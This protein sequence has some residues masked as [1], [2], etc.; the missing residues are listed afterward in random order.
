VQRGTRHLH[1]TQG[2]RFE[3]GHRCDLARAT[4]LEPNVTDASLYPLS[5]ELVGHRPSG[6]GGT[7]AQLGLHLKLVHLHYHPVG[8]VLTRRASPLSMLHEANDLIHAPQ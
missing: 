3:I 7:I 8:V 5:G 6:R 1:P 2:D 4:D